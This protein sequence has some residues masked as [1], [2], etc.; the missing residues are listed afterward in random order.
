MRILDAAAALFYQQG[1][2]AVGVDAIVA[3]SGVA[4]MSFYRHFPSKDDLIRAVLVEH[5]RRYWTW[6]DKALALHADDPR[7]Q[8]DDLLEAISERLYRP[9]YRGC[10]FI[11][12]TA[13]FAQ[14]GHPGY[15]VVIAHKR[16]QRARLRTLAGSIGARDPDLLADQLVMLIEGAR[17]SALTWSDEGPALNLPRAAKSLLAGHIGVP[18]SIPSA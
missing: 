10:A 15:S 11:N 5:D 14:V 13:E 7:R 1:I 9:A 12:F 2:H 17:V 3:E 4:K 8:M 18:A 16:Q 6:W